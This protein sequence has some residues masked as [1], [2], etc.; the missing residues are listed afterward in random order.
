MY[1]P[2]PALLATLLPL[3]QVKKVYTTLAPQVTSTLLL[4][5][6][7]QAIDAAH[8]LSNG[9]PYGNSTTHST[10][11]MRHRRSFTS[12]STLS[13]VSRS[14]GPGPGNANGNGND[15]LLAKFVL[16]QTDSRNSE[17]QMSIREIKTEAVKTYASND[18]VL[19]DLADTDFGTLFYRLDV[20]RLNI[21]PNQFL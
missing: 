17:S 21:P 20:S 8:E 13:S 2:P 12:A 9:Q 15:S 19:K 10:P 14:F 6:L 5:Y 1:S 3:P 11:P 18:T 4:P 7:K 16:L